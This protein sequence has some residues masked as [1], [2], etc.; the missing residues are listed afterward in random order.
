M[1]RACALAARPDAPQRISPRARSTRPSPRTTVKARYDE[2]VAKFVPGD[3]LHVRHILVETEDEAK[4][5]IAELDKGG[6]F[7]E[8]AK[9]KS[10][11]P[12]S[13]ASGGDLGFFGKGKMVQAFEDAAFALEVGQYT[14]A[15]VQIA[16]R[17]A[18]HQ[19]RREA[20]AGAADLRATRGRD[21]AASCCTRVLRR[22]S[23]RRCA[24][25]PRSRSSPP[26]P[27]HR[28][29][30]ADTPADADDAGPPAQLPDATSADRSAMATIS[31]LAPAA[32]PSLPAIAGVRFATAEAGIRYKNRHR[33]AA[34]GVRQGHRRSPASSPGR[35]ARRRRS[36][37]ARRRSPAARRGRCSSIPATPT[38]SP[39]SAAARR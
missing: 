26:E 15:P 22:P 11:D 20:Q 6:D 38:P 3:E 32:F 12:G 19:G 36:T 30:P 13:G 28:R 4:A 18:R 5:I 25:P 16:V 14:K 23:S 10:N 17:L 31:P 8:I 27:A 7:A 29:A 37:G 24:P 2:E 33:R 39:A 9:E 35:N 21:P 1:T 34:R